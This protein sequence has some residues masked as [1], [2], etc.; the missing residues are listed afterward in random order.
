MTGEFAAIAAIRPR[1]PDRPIRPSCGSETT[2]P[3]W[4]LPAGDHLL[5]AAD[6]VV[7]GVHAD[8]ALTGLDDLGWKADGR[9]Q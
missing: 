8:L 3:F 5:L 2:P 1:C 6:T 7:A 4:A 9:R